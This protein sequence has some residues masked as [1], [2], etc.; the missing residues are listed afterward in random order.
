MVI[1]EINENK[2]EAQVIKYKFI[3]IQE[4]QFEIINLDISNYNSI[5]EIINKIK[6]ENNIYRIILTGTRTLDIEELKNSIKVLSK[7]IIDI[8][9]ETK[10]A[11]DLNQIAK[12]KNLKGVFV[13]NM[14][15]KAEIDKENEEKYYKAIEY[16]LKGN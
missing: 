12:E 13:K 4:M 10:I 15:A 8:K 6:I 5:Q 2:N 9:D 11:I 7:N 16:V 1:G 14:L 3:P